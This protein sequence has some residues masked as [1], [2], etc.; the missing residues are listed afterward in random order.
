MITYRCT[1]THGCTFRKYSGN[2]GLV[3]R[4]M[5]I[6]ARRAD[7]EPVPMTVLAAIE[8]HPVD[9]WNVRDRMLGEMDWCP[10]GV[11]WAEWKAAALSRLF[12]K[13]GVNGKPGRITAA[14]VRDGEQKAGGND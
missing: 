13:Q 9:P 14:T 2:P 12:Q 5:S 11:V 1:S 10:E 7:G 4:K 8:Q 3:S 6:M